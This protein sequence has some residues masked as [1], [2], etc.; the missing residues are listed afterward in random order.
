MAQPGASL[1]PSE[2][3]PFVDSSGHTIASYPHPSL[4]VDTVV[5][6]LARTGAGM[7][8]LAV[9][10]A[11]TKRPDVL[12]GAWSLP[13]AFVRKDETLAD[14][15]TRS[16][17]AKAGLVGLK[18]QQL[19]VFD[20]P[21][22]DPRARVVSAAHLAAVSPGEFGALAGGPPEAFLNADGPSAE[23]AA[24][25]LFPVDALPQSLALDHDIIV[26]TAVKALQANYADLPDPARFLEEP[27]T[28][29]QLRAVHQAVGAPDQLVDKFRRHM[30][31]R[32]DAVGRTQPGHRG[33]P[34]RLFRRRDQAH[35]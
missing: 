14:A 13:G 4:A 27:F 26:D 29:S 21:D 35:P 6:T 23:P 16:L 10:L 30:A 7:P 28:L 31:E 9:W 3:G 20:D 2:E 5:L 25:A 24:P 32:L 15:V 34:A 12:K 8:A 17:E 33:R 11:P 1:S 22:R 19:K 18:P